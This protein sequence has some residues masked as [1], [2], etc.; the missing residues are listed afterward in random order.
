MLRKRTKVTSR[1]DAHP[2]T[3]CTSVFLISVFANAL[4][5]L[6]AC[7]RDDAGYTRCT[8]LPIALNH[9][10]HHGCRSD[11]AEFCPPPRSRSAEIDLV[12][13]R[14]LL[15]N[16]YRLIFKYTFYT[17]SRQLFRLSFQSSFRVC[18]RIGQKGGD[19]N[20]YRNAFPL[21][22]TSVFLIF[23]FIF[24]V[25]SSFFSSLFTWKVY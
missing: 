16:L 24:L 18:K 23:N 6:P 15:P 17:F 14:L 11:S 25:F 5:S 12:I 9:D 7:L 21:R 19:L 1:V 13:P 20:Q 22:C 4:A 3:G 10:L 8:S 2:I